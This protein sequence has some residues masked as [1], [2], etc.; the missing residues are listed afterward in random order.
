MDVDVVGVV[1]VAGVV[2]IVR[3]CVSVT[4]TTMSR[5]SDWYQSVFILVPEVPGN[6][7]RLSGIL[8]A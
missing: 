1:D 6:R 5:R 4:L 8:E 2:R 7:L 3:V